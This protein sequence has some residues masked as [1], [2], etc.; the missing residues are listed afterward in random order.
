MKYILIIMVFICGCDSLGNHI[1]QSCDEVCKCIQQYESELQDCI[2][3]EVDELYCHSLMETKF[4]ECQQIL[5]QQRIQ[6]NN[7]IMTD[8]AVGVAVG[9]ALDLF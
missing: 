9:V 5:N 6:Y 4:A 7:D 8:I 3:C 2:E 1:D